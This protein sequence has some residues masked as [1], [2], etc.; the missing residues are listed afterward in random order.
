MRI[1]RCDASRVSVL[2]STGINNQYKDIREILKTQ[3]EKFLEEVHEILKECEKES[4]RRVNHLRETESVY[5]IQKKN[6]KRCYML[7]GKSGHIAKVC[8]NRKNYKENHHKTT[9]NNRQNRKKDPDEPG[10]A[11]RKKLANNIIKSEDGNEK[12]RVYALRF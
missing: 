1:V 7:Y 8:W 9:N 3:W 5:A 6:D 10:N 4:Q 11:K 12:I 2:H